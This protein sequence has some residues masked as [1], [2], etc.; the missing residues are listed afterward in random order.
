MGLRDGEKKGKWNRAQILENARIDDGMLNCLVDLIC[1]DKRRTRAAAKLHYK[2][3][4]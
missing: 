1:M 4:E 2:R 3:A